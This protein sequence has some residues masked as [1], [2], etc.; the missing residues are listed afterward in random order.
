MAPSH[1]DTFDRDPSDE[2]L[3]DAL[4]EVRSAFHELVE[5]FREEQA[6]MPYAILS[7]LCAEMS[8]TARMLGYIDE[9]DKPSAAGL[10]LELDRLLR[11]F[12]STVRQAKK[13]AEEYIARAKQAIAEAETEAKPE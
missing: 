9:V 12:E 4:D 7:V 3:D 1:E 13:G 8:V 10:K 11:G 6:D 2:E 5:E